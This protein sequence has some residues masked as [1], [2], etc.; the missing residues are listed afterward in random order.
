MR[1]LTLAPT[2]V[3]ADVGVDGVGEVDR[4]AAGRQALHVALGRE[5]EDLVLEQVD[6]QRVHELAR[7]AGLR[8]P[9][10][11]LAQP[12]ELVGGP[13]ALLL[14]H[15]VRRDAELGRLMHVE[16]ADLDL[17]RLAARADDGR[18][19]RLV[20][21]ELGHRDVVLETPRDR[22]PDGV[23]DADRA[24]AV[25][26]RLDHDAQRRE[27]EDLVEL[28][29]APAHLVVDGVEVLGAAGDLGRDA[30]LGELV[31]RGSSAASST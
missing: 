5:D 30:G 18:V 22:L 10:H 26:D 7:V 3:V 27:V 20:H 4:R 29:A 21:V 8:L 23:D 9:L 12:G 16:G 2:A 15:P 13:V 19:Q 6:A 28:L 1:P 17:E 25:L 11:H 14:V 24:V 31:A